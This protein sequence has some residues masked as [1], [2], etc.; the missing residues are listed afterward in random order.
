MKE[1]VARIGGMKECT[2]H[3]WNEEM[4]GARVE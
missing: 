2:V 4:H 3:V 1:C